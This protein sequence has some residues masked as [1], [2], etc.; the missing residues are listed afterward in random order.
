MGALDQQ[1]ARVGVLHALHESV[2]LL[3]DHVLVD[4]VRVAQRLRGQL[5]HRVDRHAAAGQNQ[6]LHVPLLRPTQSHD[7]VLHQQVERQRVDALLVDHHEALVGVVAA[8]LVLQLDD[9]VHPLV[10]VHPL[11]RHH[12]LPLLGVAVEE[13]TVHLTLLVL[14]RDVAGQDEAVLVVLLHVRVPRAVV[15]HKPVHKPGVRG[16]LVLHVHDLNHVQ[17][18][19]LVGDLD[20][21]N[22]VGDVV[23]ELVRD[24]LLQL[25][26]E[27]RVGDAAELLPVVA[28]DGLLHLLDVGERGLL[29]DLETFHEDPGV[30]ALVQVLLGLLQQLADHQHGGGR[31]VAG[32]VV[33]RHRRPRD[34]DG[35]RVLNLHLSQQHVAVLG[36]LDVSSASDKHLDGSSGTQVGLHHFEKSLR[37]V[38]VHEEGRLGAHGLRM[39]VHLLHSCRHDDLT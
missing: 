19:G 38:D 4:L 33:L 39:G 6:P 13:A 7:A 28:V 15:Q 31:A 29:R 2:H 17:I 37:G 23:G 3:A 18:Q 11:R 8:H 10:R 21:E 34:H 36:E 27:R 12:L 25:G 9:L 32:D 20:G 22:G 26:A 1:S 24:G 30:E 35:S 5:L 14:E 16:H